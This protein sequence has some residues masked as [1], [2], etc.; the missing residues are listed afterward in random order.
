MRSG[1]TSALQPVEKTVDRAQKEHSGRGT[2][3]ASLRTLASWWLP[4]RRPFTVAEMQDFR[5]RMR[6][7]G[8]GVRVA[9]NRL[10][11]IALEGKPCESMG[12]STSRVRPCSP[13]PRTPPWPPAKVVTPTPR[14]TTSS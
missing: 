13:I 14:T 11:K 3:P 4:L 8:G 6:E 10:A 5:A 1:G 7:A 2:R 9:K 12:Q